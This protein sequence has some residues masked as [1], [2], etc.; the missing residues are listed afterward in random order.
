M[1][2]D[3]QQ[4]SAAIRPPALP[5]SR[6]AASPAVTNPRH[7]ILAGLLIGFIGEA[8]LHGQP[9]GFG[10]A[11][12]AL[13]TIGVW[14][15]AGRRQGI[16]PS[17]AG[18][19][20]LAGIAFLSLMVGVR[21]SAVMMTLNILAG[22]GLALLLAAVYV[23]GKLIRYR[24]TDY[25][26]ALFASGLATLAQPC[27][28]LSVDLRKTRSEPVKEFGMA[29]VLKGVLLAL[30]LLL[31]FGLLFASAD[32]VFAKYMRSLFD[33]FDLSDFIIR[34][35]LSLMLSWLALGLFRHALTRQADQDG[36]FLL[37]SLGFL[38]IGGLTAITVLALVNA[39]FL[40]FVAVQA[41]YLFGG[42]DT[43]ANTGLSYS[44]Y[45]RRG[46]FE[47]LTVAAL[48]LSLT[49][50]SDWLARGSAGGARRA[51]N[52]LHALLVA[53]TLLILASALLR[54]QLYTREYGL[55]ELRFYATAFMAWLAIVL[56]WFVVTVVAG[57]AFAATGNGAPDGGARRSF[58]FGA[59]FAGLAT[60]VALN[61]VNPDG[62]I[63]RTNLQRARSEVGQPLDTKYITQAL[64][65][66]AVPALLA[67]MTTLPDA[68][69]HAAL[70][71][72]LREKHRN[73]IKRNSGVTWRG[74]NMSTITAL[75]LLAAADKRP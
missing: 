2:D 11:G 71:G 43:L 12:A 6:D 9:P 3:V 74:M 37:D 17:A 52:L 27:L 63:V 62:L 72:A 60:V 7:L 50:L 75:R 4:C 55:T 39:L 23:P 33:W 58:A 48:V 1:N 67:G 25:V 20:L 29:P 24:L 47:L 22:L 31:I 35:I 26:L 70:A 5:A 45:A 32:A 10:Y 59:F 30:P 8:F 44:E 68:K 40:G 21:A 34:L 56:A 61:L 19:C 53:L 18:W 65:A 66:D 41:V 51:I 54:M 57:F 14:L 64:S 28:A 15:A 13:A 16:R 69:V 46:F 38:R 42:A 36:D 49:L 73:L